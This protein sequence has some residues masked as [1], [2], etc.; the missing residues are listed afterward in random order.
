MTETAQDKTALV[1]SVNLFSDTPADIVD[2]IATLL[3][4]RHFEVGEVIFRKGDPGDCMY[5]V[6]HGS[7]QIHDEDLILN[8]LHTGDVFGEMALLD[9]ESRM[10]SAMASEETTVFKLGQQSFYMFMESQPAVT[11]GIIRVLCNRLRARVYDMTQDHEYI[12]QIG[13][14]TAAAEALE[15]GVYTTQSLENVCGRDDALGTLARVFRKMAD[16]IQAREE[17]LTRHVQ[18]LQ[19]EVD[20][21]RRALDVQNIVETDF[22]RNLQER[23]KQMR[24]PKDS[25][26]T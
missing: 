16:E 15:T 20:Q 10:A 19:I 1:R 5:I 2:Q 11:R 13:H 22:F 23:A 24:R 8:V 7:V 21:A 12:Q 6:G 14:I 26:E 4:P 25:P 9:A 3:E 17:R 18:E